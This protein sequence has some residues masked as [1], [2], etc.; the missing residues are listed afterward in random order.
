MMVRP[1]VDK[2]QACTGS[3][4]ASRRSTRQTLRSAASFCDGWIHYESML[5]SHSPHFVKTDIAEADLLIINY[6]SG[7]TAQPK[8]VM[9]AHR[10]AYI[11]IMGTLVHHLSRRPTDI[12]GPCPV[13]RERMD[14]HLD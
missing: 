6:T 1:P 10:N 11:N 2:R 12:P 8:G 9:I 13:P 5:G 14:V 4:D 3:L 7:T